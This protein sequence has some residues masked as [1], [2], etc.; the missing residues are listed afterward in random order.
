M[1]D[2]KAQ[3]EA[4]S[5]EVEQIVLDMYKSCDAQHR[6]I[7]VDLLKKAIE[8][9]ITPEQLRY[10]IMR[11]V[12]RGV[13]KSTQ[14]DSYYFN[15]VPEKEFRLVKADTPTKVWDANRMMRTCHLGC[16]LRKS[17]TEED[18]EEVNKAPPTP[19]GGGGNATLPPA[20]VEEEDDVPAQQQ[21]LLTDRHPGGVG[22][23]TPDRPEFGRQWHPDDPQAQ[24]PIQKGP[25]WTYQQLLEGMRDNLQKSVPA[26]VTQQ[27]QVTPKEA[28]FMQEEL[29]RSPQDIA[30]GNTFMSPSQRKHFNMWLNKGL[31]KSMS[32]LENWLERN[33]G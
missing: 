28:Q 18:E 29:G 32:S 12:R 27:R 16:D 17:M 20:V 23:A 11:D 2:E 3:P 6:A 9:G 7:D 13:V 30:E 10:G 5:A 26:A 8:A 14:G 31:T 33:R 19:G 25:L 4:S 21:D 22:Q 1:S 24:A 15:D